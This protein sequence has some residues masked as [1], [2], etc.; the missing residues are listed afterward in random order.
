VTPTNRPPPACGPR[1]PVLA[2]LAATAAL[3]FPAGPAHAVPVASLPAGLAGVYRVHNSA[4]AGCGYPRVQEPLQLV[5]AVAG[6]AITFTVHTPFGNT[7]ISATDT[8]DQNADGSYAITGHATA[9]TNGDLFTSWPPSG[10]VTTGCS[11]GPPRPR[12]PLAASSRCPW[13]VPSP[14]SLSIPAG[15]PVHR[16][17]TGAPDSLVDPPV[18]CPPILTA[19]TS[20]P[21]GSCDLSRFGGTHGRRPDP[22]PSCAECSAVFR[23]KGATA[24]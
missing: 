8:V 7:I 6:T 12:T 10:W 5:V 11:T 9:N 1:P 24:C 17:S 3:L 20:D 2:A 21:P 16:P 15:G 13:P 4:P 23:K 14:S 19:T 22:E 18:P